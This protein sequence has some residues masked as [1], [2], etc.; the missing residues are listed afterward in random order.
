[1]ASTPAR[2]FSSARRAPRPEGPLTHFASPRG[3]KCRLDR[4][5]NRDGTQDPFALMV[6]T[7]TRDDNRDAEL[8]R[9]NERDEGLARS[10]GQCVDGRPRTCGVGI[11]RPD[12]PDC[13]PRTASVVQKIPIQKERHH[14]ENKVSVLYSR[15]IL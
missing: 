7:F 9:P 14:E 4:R 2:A 12:D 1:M 10:C 15:C 8:E 6:F 3:E 13:R 5:P 11:D